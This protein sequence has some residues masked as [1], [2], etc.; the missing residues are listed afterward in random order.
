MSTRPISALVAGALLLSACAAPGPAATV[1]GV[2]FAPERV[3]DLHPEGA[4]L[5]AE[6]RASS[7]FLVILHHLVAREADA[8]FDVTAGE[9]D[10]DAAVDERLG[11]SDEISDQRLAERGVTRERV[12]LEAELDVLRS[13]IQRAF[14]DERAPG[15]DLD[16]AYRRFLSVNSRVCVTLL[17][18]ASPEAV[19]DVEA[20]V[21][22]DVDLDDVIEQLGDLVEPVE[23]GCDSPVGLPPPVQPVAVDGEVG[24]AY[25]STFSDGTTYVA[26]VTERDAPAL[27][28]VLGDVENLAA[29]TQGTELFDEWAFELLRTAT[30]EID[31][32][33]GTWE[34]RDGTADVPTVVPPN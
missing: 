9:T 27:E 30:V 31:S 20:A 25:L 26:G 32:D 21:T 3:T 7:L 16:A 13:R 10:I 19:A 5:D 22:G 14:V 8:Q 23:L 4:D 17:A 15:V 28:D 11:D 12:R 33:F 29:E 18:P 34:P 24:R 6:Q 2:E 1:D